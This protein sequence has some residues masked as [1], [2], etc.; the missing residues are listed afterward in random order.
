METKAKISKIW[1]NIIDVDEEGE[2][3]ANYVITMT[4]HEI[5][6]TQYLQLVRQMK[7]KNDVAVIIGFIQPEL[8]NMDQVDE[9]VREALSIEPN[10]LS[11]AA[12]F[13]KDQWVR[14]LETGGVAQISRIV[15]G[16]TEPMFW[17]PTD[18]Q[19]S[20]EYRADQIEAAD[21][22]E[23]PADP[24]AQEEPAAEE[25]TEPEASETPPTP[26]RRGPNKPKE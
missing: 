26:R 12:G 3:T 5:D 20:R 2:A 19:E 6:R 15:M 4:L 8:V 24:D 1:E 22:P 25:S 17:V 13:K 9:Q 7:A 21:S 11:E 16:A 18:G 23:P 14:I 10:T